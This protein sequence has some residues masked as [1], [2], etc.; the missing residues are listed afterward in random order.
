MESH[1][2]PMFGGY[3]SSVNGD[4]KYLLCYV[5]SQNHLIEGSCDFLSGSS[6]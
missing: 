1:H 3:W 2:F 4:I 5:T 6:L